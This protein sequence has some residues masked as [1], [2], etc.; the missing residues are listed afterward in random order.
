MK[1]LP[2][3]WTDAV[4]D[5]H[6]PEGKE[7]SLTLYGWSTTSLAHAAQVAQQRWAQVAAAVRAGRELHTQ[8]YYPRIPLREE[9]LQEIHAPDGTLTA[10]ITRNRYGAEVLNTDAVLIADVDL[11][12]PART[13]RSPRRSG[14]G[15]LAGLFRRLVGRRSTSDLLAPPPSGVDMPPQAPTSGDGAAHLS[16]IAAV[17]GANTRWGFR[18]YRT[19]AG[20]RVIVTG[21]GLA[22]GSAEAEYLLR[23]LDSDPLYVRLCATHE[24]YRARLTPK[25]WRV[26]HRALIVDYPYDRFSHIVDPWLRAYASACR[27]H[28]ACELVSE[29]GPGAT[30]IERQ[31]VQLHDERAGVGS[32]SPLA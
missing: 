22:P 11:P 12:Q 4:G 26:G 9:V 2:R 19:A 13:R 5:A 21:S 15:P 18:V 32:G 17:A 29:T 6:S 7:F 23:E 24:T 30:G 31:I 8:W 20:L 1:P 25:P 3:F 14:S 28:A 16:R 10:A 27:G